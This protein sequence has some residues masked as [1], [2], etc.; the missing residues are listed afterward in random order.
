MVAPPSERRPALDPELQALMDAMAD[1]G[2]PPIMTVEPALARREFRERVLK[3]RAG[4]PVTPVS[5]V[6]DRRVP[7]DGGAEDAVPVRVYTPRSRPAHD[8]PAVVYLHGGGWVIGDLDT[9]EPDCRRLADATGALVVGVDYRLA[10]EHP[11]PA[12]LEDTWAVL[13][14]A[15]HRYG[16]VAVAGDSAGGNLA[17]ALVLRA[18]DAG[19]PQVTAQMLNYPVLDATASMPSYEEFDEGPNLT[20]GEMRWFIGAYLPREQDR[21]NPLASPLLAADLAG[22]PPAVVSTAGYDPLRD[23]GDRYAERLRAAGVEVVHRRYDSLVH[24][25]V[26]LGDGVA[27]CRVARDEVFAEFAA[28]LAARR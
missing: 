6:E 15:A 21:R 9:Y 12:A 20:S 13:C 26:G 3:Q 18:R 25:F 17:A 22:L 16:R 8:L 5:T 27:A 1:L 23:E 11:F 28:M 7:R 4:R 24:G 14:W 10:P 2:D 19:G